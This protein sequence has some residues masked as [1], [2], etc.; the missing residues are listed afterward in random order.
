MYHRS[1]YLWPPVIVELGVVLWIFFHPTVRMFSAS[2][3]ADGGH[4][5]DPNLC[6]NPLLRPDPMRREACLVGVLWGRCAGKKTSSLFGHKHITQ[7]DCACWA[8]R[9][10]RGAPTSALQKRNHQSTPHIPA[11]SCVCTRT[12]IW[13]ICAQGLN[14]LCDAYKPQA[15]LRSNR[16]EKWVHT[17]CCGSSL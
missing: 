11:E 3:T 16:H 10:T 9:P 15:T 5:H 12:Y 14:H 7:G 1:C 6:C 13:S 4:H 2:A 17:H 8:G